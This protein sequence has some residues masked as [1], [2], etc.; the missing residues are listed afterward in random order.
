MVLNCGVVK[1]FY[2]AVLHCRGTGALKDGALSD[3]VLMH[4][5]IVHCAILCKG[6]CALRDGVLCDVV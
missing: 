1:Q 6:N 5:G 2:G 3:I 4:Y